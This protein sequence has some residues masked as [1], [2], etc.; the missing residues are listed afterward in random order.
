MYAWVSSSS[1]LV[2]SRIADVATGRMSWM[3]VARQ[4]WANISI[5]SS[6]RSIGSG[7]SA[8]DASRPSPTRTLS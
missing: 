4:K 6:A 7:W 5:V 1:R 8:P 3:P 2:A